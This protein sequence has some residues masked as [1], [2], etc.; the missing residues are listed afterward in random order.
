MEVLVWGHRRRWAGVRTVFWSVEDDVD[1][2]RVVVHKV[3][4]V[5]GHHPARGARRGRLLGGHTGITAHT[6]RSVPAGGRTPPP[7]PLPKLHGPSGTH[8]FIT[9]ISLRFDGEDIGQPPQAG[10]LRPDVPPAAPGGSNC[11]IEPSVEN[12]RTLGRLSSDR[13]VWVQ[14]ERFPPQAK[15]LETPYKR[16]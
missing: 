11:T 14:A 2:T 12:G 4:L 3:D 9:S 1:V 6:L 13:R 16:T 7:N 15:F 10:L 8:S 5:V